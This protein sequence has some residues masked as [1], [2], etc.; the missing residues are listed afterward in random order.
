MNKYT[1]KADRS[2]IELISMRTHDEN[3]PE[4]IIIEIKDD[5]DDL[6]IETRRFIDIITNENEPVLMGSGINDLLRDYANEPLV[7]LVEACQ[8]IEH[9]LWNL[10]FYVNEALRRTP[11]KPSDGLTVDESASIRLYTSEWQRGQ[12]S[13]Y[14]HLNSILNSGDRQALRPYFKYLKLFLSGLVR[15]PCVPPSTVWRGVTRNLSC[16]FPA[17]QSVTWWAFSSCTTQLPVL[18]NNKFLGQIGDRT[19]FSAEV[20]NGRSINKHSNYPNEDEVLL[21][22][23]THFIVQSQL[24]PAANLYVIH[25]KQIIPSKILLQ[26]PFEGAQIYPQTTT[27]T[28]K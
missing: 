4:E 25:L 28:T 21:L 8:P 5:D 12:E 13:L 23:A 1:K 10:S 24:S 7:S 14:S 27:T 9:L 19:L 11:S 6:T 2:S 26:P 3:K 16:R 18:K 20:I 17:G 15:L 22:P